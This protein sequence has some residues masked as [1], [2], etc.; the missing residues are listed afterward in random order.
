MSIKEEHKYWYDRGYVSG[1]DGTNDTGMLIPREFIHDYVQGSQD[2]Y[3]KSHPNA[4]IDVPTGNN[5]N[6]NL[7]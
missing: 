4:I 6:N 1:Y 2:G 5:N 3:M 7:E